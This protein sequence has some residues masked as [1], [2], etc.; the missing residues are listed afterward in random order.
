[1]ILTT[2]GSNYY[3][4]DSEMIQLKEDVEMLEAQFEVTQEYHAKRYKYGI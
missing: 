3:L 1:M 4:D 2:S